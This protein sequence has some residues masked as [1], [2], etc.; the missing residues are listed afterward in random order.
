MI[1]A[2]CGATAWLRVRA[3]TGDLLLCQACARRHERRVLGAPL[4]R[5]LQQLRPQPTARVQCPF[6]GTTRDHIQQTGLYGCCLCYAIWGAP[7]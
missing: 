6:C 7:P 1:C 3:G 4:S 5:W 2:V